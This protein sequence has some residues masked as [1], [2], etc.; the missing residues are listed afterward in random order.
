[1]TVPS[2]VTIL[3][4]EHAAA[5]RTRLKSDPTILVFMESEVLRALEAIKAR[6]PKVLV[7]DSACVATSR[8]AM[9]VAQMKRDPGLRGVDLRVMNPDEDKLPLGRTKR[10]AAIEAMLLKS[11][12]PLDHCGTRRSVRW[13]VNGGL[14]ILVNGKTGHLVNLSSTGAQILVAAPVRPLEML[15]L[16]VLDG[17][18]DTRLRARVAWCAAETAASRMRYRAGIEFIDLNPE[19]IDLLCIRYAT[20]PVEAPFPG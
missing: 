18:R 4:S 19:L 12:Q 7:L 20:P 16:T 10:V 3:R 5:L 6:R 8:G 2:V 13:D 14:E 17:T 15:R 11:S 1:M 9:L